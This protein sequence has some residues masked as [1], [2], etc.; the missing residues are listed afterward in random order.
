MKT[1]DRFTLLVI[2]DEENVQ[3]SLKRYFGRENYLILFACNGEEA[4]RIVSEQTVDM[5]L[6]D[7]NMPGMDGLVVLEKILDIQP[8]LKVIMLTGYG[9]VQ[10]AVDAMKVGAVDFFEK[11]ISPDVLRTK[12]EHFYHI[13]EL[14][15]E[16]KTLQD[17]LNSSFTYDG[18]IGES[19]PML[20]LKEIITRIA[21]T[22]ISVLIQGESGTGKELI[23]KA[24]HHHSLRKSRVFMPVD[25]AA[26]SENV[27]ESELFGHK[28]GA[29]TGADQSTMGLI[30]SADKGTL[31][32]DEVGELPVQMQ[33][34][35]LRT[36]QE[37][38]VRPVGSTQ[39]I[40]VDVRIVAA[41]NRNL[42]DAVSNG[43]FRQDLY[44]R[45][46]AMTIH[47]PPLR[48]RGEDIQVLSEHFASGMDREGL[49]PKGISDDAVQV[50]RRHAWEGNVRELENVIRTA[51]AFARGDTIGASDLSTIS[52][53]G[54]LPLPGLDETSASL[55]DYE[56]EAIRKA[57]EMSGGNRR[58][59]AKKLGIS[60]ATLYRRI[61]L[62]NF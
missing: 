45:L 35:L 12:V 62:Y 57:L 22:D 55:S 42:A 25:C 30:R 16:N 44:Y 49:S 31:F 3:R 40:P 54:T 29:F 36:I 5:A 51:T 10:L 26:I 59:A 60:E 41:T 2:D 19:P 14:E 18:L 28:R 53:N 15:H 17:C 34:K 1:K 8:D 20:K 24:I 47:A 58:S 7:Y 32:L 33:V 23:A 6:L 37:Q 48:D 39:L 21:P 11:T 43:E 46:S 9:G 56:E 4:I 27:M 38:T 50:L 13:W 52:M 61:K